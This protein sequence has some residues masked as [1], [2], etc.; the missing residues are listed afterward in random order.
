MGLVGVARI[1]CDHRQVCSGPRPSG[2]IRP[3]RDGVDPGDELPEAQDPLQ[4]LR[5]I[6]HR[7]MT[8]AA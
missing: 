4:R 5:A 8:A 1:G 3:A 7:R 2:V 6:A